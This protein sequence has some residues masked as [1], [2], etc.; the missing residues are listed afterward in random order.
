MSLRVLLRATVLSGVLSHGAEVL[1]LSKHLVIQTS[2]GSQVAGGCW[3][4]KLCGA[5]TCSPQNTDENPPRLI[6]VESKQRGLK[7][8]RAY[9]SYLQDVARP[10]AWFRWDVVLQRNSH[11]S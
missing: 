6:K 9:A 8:D 5:T 2:I 11:T 4:G 3:L 1:H 7:E 10:S